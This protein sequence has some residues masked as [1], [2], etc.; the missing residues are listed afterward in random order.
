MINLSWFFPHICNPPPTC[1]PN[2]S[3]NSSHAPRPKLT[4]CCFCPAPQCQDTYSPNPLLG[5]FW[6]D[7]S[8]AMRL[9]EVPHCWEPPARHGRDARM[10][11]PA[12]YNQWAWQH[13]TAEEL[14]SSPSVPGRHYRLF[15]SPSSHLNPIQANEHHSQE[16]RTKLCNS[17][18]GFF[19]FFPPLLFFL[20]M[21]E[22]LQLMQNK[23]GGGTD[24]KNTLQRGSAM[25]VNPLP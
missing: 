2:C 3:K 19:F 9:A 6:M 16:L 4:P 5:D 13:L 18:H 8:Q 1:S 7:M 22:Y 17:D 21:S 12:R 14:Q 23:P 15:A 25:K 24:V 10:Q 11:A 20:T